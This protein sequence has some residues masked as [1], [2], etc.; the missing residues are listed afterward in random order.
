MRVQLERERNLGRFLLADLL[1]MSGW[2][3]I[4]DARYLEQTSIG[5]PEKGVYDSTIPLGDALER[6]ALL[7]DRLNG[8]TLPMERGY[9]LRLLDFGLYGYKSVKGLGILE[10]TDKFQLGEW[11][12]RAGYALDGQIQPKRYRFCDLNRHH[13]ITQPGEVTDI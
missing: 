11:E 7:I 8:E 9:P 4:T 5:T 3:G 12:R 6:R 10:L 2:D 1:E 13:F